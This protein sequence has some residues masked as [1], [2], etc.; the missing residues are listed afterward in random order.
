MFVSS[1]EVEDL[2][3]RSSWRSAGKTAAIFEE[4]FHLGL[5]GMIVNLVEPYRRA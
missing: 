2:L 5:P 3:L 4:T 1:I